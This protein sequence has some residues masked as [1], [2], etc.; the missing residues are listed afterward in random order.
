MND[1]IFEIVRAQ[2]KDFKFI[3]LK[4]QNLGIIPSNVKYG[5]AQLKSMTYNSTN[6]MN[7]LKPVRIRNYTIMARVTTIINQSSNTTQGIGRW[8]RI[9]N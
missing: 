2:I 7:I 3:P 5:F 4:Y 8:T 6:E 9:N 1:P